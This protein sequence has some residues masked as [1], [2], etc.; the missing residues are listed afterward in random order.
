MSSTVRDLIGVLTIYLLIFYLLMAIHYLYYLIL[1]VCLYME[2]N[3]LNYNIDD[4]HIM[5]KIVYIVY[6]IY[7]YVA[8]R[9]AIRKIRKIANISH[10]RLLPYINYCNYID[11]ILERRCIRFLYNIFNSEN[12]LYA[13]MVKY[14][15]TNCDPTRII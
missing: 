3:C 2:V 8:W 6:Y 7:I 9:K 1:T 13:S 4:R 5:I 12:K 14:S 11:S 15:L 10:C